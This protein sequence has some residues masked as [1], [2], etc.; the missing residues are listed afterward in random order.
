M[1]TSGNLPAAIL[2]LSLAAGP[3][4]L[5]ASAPRFAVVVGANR[6]DPS[7]RPLR[8]AEDDA[9]RVAEALRTVGRFPAD[10]IAVVTSGTAAEVREVLQRTNARLRA[11]GGDSLL[12]VFYSGHGDADDLHLGG[13]RLSAQELTTLMAGSPASSRVLVVDACRSGALTRVKG[14]RP[15]PSFSVALDLPSPPQG[16]ATLTSSGSTEDAQESDGLQSSFFTHYF[17]SGL[18]GAADHNNDGWVTLGEVFTFASNET[19]LATS[20]TA[21]GPQHPTYH[22]QLGGRQDLVLAHTRALDGGV[23]GLQFQRAGRYL[24]QALQPDG[25]RHAA[26]EISAGS[27]GARLALPAGRYQVLLRAGGKTWEGEVE[28]IAGVLT[29]TDASKLQ[30]V[31]YPELVHKG[32][33]EGRNSVVAQAG[34]RSQ[35]LDLGRGAGVMVGGRRHLRQLAMEARLTYER[36]YQKNY[37]MQMNTHTI[38][39][40]VMI[41]RPIV[42]APVVFVPGLEVGAFLLR[43]VISPQAGSDWPLDPKQ[44][45]DATSVGA[46]VAPV[47]ALEVPLPWQVFA[48][49]EAAL[50]VHLLKTTGPSNDATTSRFE[51]NRHFRMLGGAG[52]HF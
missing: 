11:T 19:L 41:Q 38:T 43:Q 13:T 20:R 42:T 31:E 9:R 30:P 17:A 45:P 40:S 12:F 1:I 46:L 22:Y 28:V 2:M 33:Y 51:L 49:V 7:D 39:P 8:Y 44:L 27:A 36:S 15:A 26:A 50:P 6:G 18:R 14:G 10:Q 32:A 34:G 16:F 5:A 35:F 52:I 4:A 23:G 21:R 24:V 3:A 29:V 47:L 48:R 37:Q 25:R